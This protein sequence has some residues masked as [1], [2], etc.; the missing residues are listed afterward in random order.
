V[1]AAAHLKLVPAEAAEV[2]L[3]AAKRSGRTGVLQFDHVGFMYGSRTILDNV[4]FRVGEGEMMS[5]LGPSGCGKTT[6]LN[7]IAGFLLPTS[8]VCL[9]NGREITKP[10]PDRSVVFQSAA[11]F[12]WM[13]VAE[14]IAFSLR[15][16]GK[17]S[18][19]REAAAR[20]MSTL[21]GLADRLD[22]YP[23]ELSGG[24]RQRVGL[25][26][27]LAAKPSV[28]LMDEPFSALDVQTR[29]N[30]QEE[31]IRIQRHTGATII[32]VTH[33]IDEAIFLGH[34]IFLATAL[35]TGSFEEYQVDLPEPRDDSE[36]RLHPNFLKLRESIYRRMRSAMRGAPSGGGG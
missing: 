23:Y 15:C 11:L 30:L 13:S 7:L 17:S 3:G 36:N 22:A 34:R 1:G 35:V 16:A 18:R 28:M 27:V 2:T 10:G 9:S 8:G 24:M 25:A 4:S 32:F 21:V 26:R 14:N 29:E 12:D 20:E 6:I 5:L 19:E 31:L 33:S